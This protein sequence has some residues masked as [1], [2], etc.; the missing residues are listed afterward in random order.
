MRAE[1]STF[2]A[3]I[4]SLSVPDRRGVLTN[5]VLGYDDTADYVR[6]TNFI[7]GVIGRYA[8]RIAGGRCVI[9]GREVSLVRNDGPNQLHG[10]NPGFHKVHWKVQFVDS[11]SI[12]F[13]YLSPAG[14]G[15][16]PGNLDV[17]V[18]YTLDGQTLAVSYRATTDAETV[19]N[20]TN[21]P[22]FNL[23]GRGLILD[24]ELA[25]FASRFTPVDDSLIPTGELRE[26]QG[27]SLDFRAS[28][29]IGESEF[30]HNFVLDNQTGELA[31]AAT[32]REPSSGRQLDLW[33]TEPGLQL[34]TGSH[35]PGDP[36]PVHAGVCL[37]LQH[38]PDSPN[39]AEF[40]STL[41]RPGEEY[42]SESEYRFSNFG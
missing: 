21:H 35:L 39:H 41:L 26:V 23:S 34:Y 33:T 10:G 37:E 7:A 2:G 1:L 5:V 19:V 42:R 17:S 18:R 14:D 22:Y 38:F 6:D 36:F 3:G 30:D 8:N 11:H 31:L 29:R 12:H 16:F 27:T 25:I 4:R 15:G 13:S 28:T 32:L 9:G 40:P 24:H 20:L